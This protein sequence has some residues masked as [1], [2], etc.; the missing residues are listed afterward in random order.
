[1]PRNFF[2]RVE[3]LFP[4]EDPELRRWVVEELFPPELRDTANARLL[5]PN[6]SYLPAGRPASGRPFSAQ[7]HFMSSATR[8]ASAF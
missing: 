6:G 1:M 4:I 8:R 2:R 3:V 7:A 5:Q